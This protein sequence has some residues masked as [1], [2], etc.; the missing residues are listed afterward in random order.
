MNFS[1]GLILF[2]QNL[3]RGIFMPVTSLLLLSRGTQLSDIAWLM[4]LYSFT[5]IC[6][7]FPS[8]AF[9]DLFGR[10][11]LFFSP[12]CFPCCLY[13]SFFCFHCFGLCCCSDIAWTGESLCFR[14]SGSSVHGT[15]SFLQ[16]G[17]CLCQSQQS[18]KS[19]SMSWNWP[20]LT[21]GRT[22]L[23][24]RITIQQQPS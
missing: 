12:A 5:V 9:C 19:F 1:F 14:Q 24:N 23:S 18:D 22:S 10:K 7:E 16:R 8:G 15:G 20:W 17:I 6:M 4:G 3:S 21:F 2:L 13:F 11:G